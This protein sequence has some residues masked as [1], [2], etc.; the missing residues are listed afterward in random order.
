MNIY[1]ILAILVIIAVLISCMRR[2][3]RKGFVAELNI[4]VSL[5][6]AFYTVRLLIRLTQDWQERRFS[7]LITGILLIGLLAAFYKLYR[8]LFSMIHVLAELP[9]INIADS[10]L[11]L[12]LGFAEGFII[13][14]FL[15]YILRH[16]LL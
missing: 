4:F 12:I 7:D 6:L 16:Y 2:G 14:Y 5:L 11:G 13:L 9:V 15:E 8:F 1:Y 10:I 3:F